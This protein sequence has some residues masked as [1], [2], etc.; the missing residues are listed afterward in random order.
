MTSGVDH[1]PSCSLVGGAGTVMSD[2]DDDTRYREH[3]A[4]EI[5]SGA[6]RRGRRTG[7]PHVARTRTH[8]VVASPAD[9]AYEDLIA[10]WSPV[11]HWVEPEP[12]HGPRLGSID[13]RLVRI[14]AVVVAVVLAVPIALA[15]RSEPKEGLRA[16]AGPATTIAA[17]ALTVPPTVAAA[18]TTPATVP[19]APPAAAPA[20]KAARSGSSASAGGA[21]AVERAN[22]ACGGI[23][24]VIPNDYWN[25]FPKSSGAS[26]AKWLAANDATADTPLYVGDKL[27]IP[28][29]AKAPT[30]PPMTDAPTTAAPATTQAP[31][32]TPAAPPPPPVRA[33][34]TTVAPVVTQAPAP[35]APRVLASPAAAA[36]AV[37]AASDP[38]VVEAL[39]REIWPD[40]LEE[41]ALT[42]ARRE[43]HLTPSVHNWCCY[44]VFAIYFDMGKNFLPQMGITRPEQLLDPRTNILA[45][46]KLYTLAGWS[47]WAQTDPGT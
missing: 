32:T 42:I 24:T 23:Y 27:C 39:I 9:D 19:P 20:V 29:G 7:R 37:P 41:R 4:D 34:P 26:V 28:A 21:A 5:P 43:S 25:R 22:P 16:D 6:P 10:D 35:P 11:A 14:G 33:A 38:A 3:A 45:A 18:P 1:D 36:A 44:G 46:Y 15:M 31:A 17:A 47:P 8:H 40:D 13:P 30:P 12:H 2:F